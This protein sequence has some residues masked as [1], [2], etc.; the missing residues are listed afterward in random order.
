MSIN[1]KYFVP[2]RK[3]HQIW[4]HMLPDDVLMQFSSAFSCLNPKICPYSQIKQSLNFFSSQIHELMFGYFIYQFH[5]IAMCVSVFFTMVLAFERFR[6][7]VKPVEYYN[8][9]NSNSHPWCTVGLFYVTPVVVISILFNAPKFFETQ[10]IETVILPDGQQVSKEIFLNTTGHGQVN[11][12]K[13]LYAYKK[14]SCLYPG[15]LTTWFYVHNN[16]ISTYNLFLQFLVNDTRWVLNPTPLR[17]NYHYVLWYNNVAR[18]LYNLI[19]YLLLLSS[20]FGLF[21]FFIN[22]YRCIVTGLLPVAG[23]SYLNYRIY[24][25]I[26]H[27][28]G[29]FMNHRGSNHKN[30]T[31]AQKVEEKR[32]AFVLFAIVILF[33][34]CHVLRW[35]SLV[36][37]WNCGFFFSFEK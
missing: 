27:R 33:V 18:W 8:A 28:R 5:N 29:Q 13:Y 19:D 7:V 4:E 21:T 34:V 35:V 30:Q 2:G 3:F 24:D 37:V 6:A 11:I 25:Q 31:H 16:L 17:S 9:V 14:A 26:K 12:C 15:W 1:S 32:Q 10:F 20:G 23:L 22:Y 36:L